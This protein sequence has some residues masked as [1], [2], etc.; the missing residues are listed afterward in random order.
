MSITVDQ[1]NNN[2]DMFVKL[3]SSINRPGSDIP[4]LLDKLENSDFYFAPASTKYHNAYK[5]GL[6]EHCLNVFNN[7]KALV[8][9]KNLDSQ[10]SEESL[11]IVALLHDFSKMNIYE[12]VF[13]NKKFYHPN[14]K[15][16][17]EGGKYDWQAIA[18]FQT[19]D[20]E[21]CF[22][23]GNHEYTSDFMIRCFIPLSCE[24]SVAITHHMGGKGF[25][26][27]QDN[28]TAIYNRYPLASLLHIA[29]MLSTYLDERI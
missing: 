29:D 8:K 9:F 23:Y 14:G 16:E 21:N 3:I 6:C 18:A 19:K 1:I 10:Y 12:E 5:G 24:E 15:K 26:S 7:L 22:L 13:K 25:D 4:G 11:I 27:A 28:I 2:K 17:D 20:A